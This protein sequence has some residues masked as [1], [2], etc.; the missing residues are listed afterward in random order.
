MKN[1]E[2]LRFPDALSK[3]MLVKALQKTQ[4][5]R[6]ELDSRLP[7]FEPTCCQVAKLT[8]PVRSPANRISAML[9]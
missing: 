6:L 4:R 2:T 1:Q 9:W 5:G 7:V 3:K 8:G